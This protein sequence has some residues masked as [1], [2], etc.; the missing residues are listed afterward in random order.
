MDGRT[1][2]LKTCWFSLHVCTDTIWLWQ[3]MDTY[4]L[5]HRIK[6]FARNAVFDTRIWGDRW[7]TYSSPPRCNL[8]FVFHILLIAVEIKHHS[9]N[10]Y[11][12]YFTNSKAISFNSNMMDFLMCTCYKLSPEYNEKKCINVVLLNV[13]C[14][15]IEQLSYKTHFPWGQL[16][17]WGW[18]PLLIGSGN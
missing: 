2:K 13:T 4:L 8:L 11:K 7:I 18:F 1:W 15:N 12:Q 10:A 9:R 16:F 3:L 6:N 5:P 14:W 17:L